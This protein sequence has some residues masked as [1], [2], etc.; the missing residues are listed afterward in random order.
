MKTTSFGVSALAIV[1]FT[2]LAVVQ[3]CT[4]NTRAT[5]L[6]DN[7]QHALESSLSTA[8][9]DNSYTIATKDELVGDV[10]EGIAL[11]MDDL[12][13]EDTLTLDVNE[14]DTDLGIVSVTATLNY[15]PVTGDKTKDT[16]GD[17][18][19]D[20]DDESKYTT[21]TAE[22]TVI[23]DEYDLPQV[24]KYTITYIVVDKDGNEAIYKSYTL[25]EGVNAMVP[26]DPYKGFSGKWYLGGS[27]PMTKEQIANT[28]LTGDMVFYSKAI[29]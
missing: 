8:M 20:N 21:V 27:T 12:G 25:S 23:F 13:P 4:V 17:G 29:H 10:I 14:V 16:N 1:F 18:V 9:S 19:V 24:G 26:K 2:I 22:K 6:E 5:N 11:Y 15:V 3:L 28:K 7:L